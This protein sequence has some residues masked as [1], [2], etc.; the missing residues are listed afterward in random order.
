MKRSYWA[1]LAVLAAVLVA[2]LVVWLT[3]G[4]NHRDIDKKSDCW[5]HPDANGSRHCATN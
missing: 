4:T 5:T 2:V 3:T 1:A